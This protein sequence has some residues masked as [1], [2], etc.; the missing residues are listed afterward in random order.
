M[1][2]KSTQERESLS[3]VLT[4]KLQLLVVILMLVKGSLCVKSFATIRTKLNVMVTTRMFIQ[5]FY[6]AK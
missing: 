3:T 1:L 5:F 4:D 2:F 6:V